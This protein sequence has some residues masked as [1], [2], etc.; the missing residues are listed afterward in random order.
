MTTAPKTDKVS[1]FVQV[2]HEG[3]NTNYRLHKDDLTKLGTPQKVCVFASDNKA[4]FAPDDVYPHGR[5]QAQVKTFVGS[6]LTL[7]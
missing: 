4:Y 7:V 5:Y 6:F 1:N 2:H 3:L